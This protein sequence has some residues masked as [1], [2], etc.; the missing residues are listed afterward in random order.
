MQNI[1][2]STRSS[3]LIDLEQGKRIEVEALQGAAVR[4]A[5][6]HGVAVP[7]IVDAVCVIEAVGA[8]PGEVSGAS[9]R[10][11]IGPGVDE[12]KCA[13]QIWILVD[14]QPVQ[15]RHDRVE[16]RVVLTSAGKMPLCERRRQLDELVR[17]SASLPAA[18]AHGRRAI[19]AAV[20]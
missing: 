17:R 3:L 18:A 5:K 19:I 7:I 15:V 10:S 20:T 16:P 14:R 6:K 4:R 12:W 9:R 2:S 13:D 11:S 1:P 8:R